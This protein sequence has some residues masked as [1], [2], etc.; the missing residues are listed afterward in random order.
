MGCSET[1][2]GPPGSV[3]AYK[4]PAC[5]SILELLFQPTIPLGAGTM[6]LVLRPRTAQVPRTQLL[7]LAWALTELIPPSGMPV[8]SLDAVL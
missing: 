7:C 8:L 3:P 5:V 4:N 1:R 6:S 2:Q